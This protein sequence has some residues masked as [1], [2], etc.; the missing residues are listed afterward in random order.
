MGKNE[1]TKKKMGDFVLSVNEKPKVN[2]AD[3]YDLASLYLKLGKKE[4]IRGDV[5]FAQAIKETGYFRFNGDVS[6]NQNNYA[7]IGAIGGGVFGASFNT[8][9]EGVRAHIQHLK[10]YA[11]K[12]NLNTTKIDPRFDLVSRGIAPYW[13][14]LNGRW[15]VPGIEYGQSIIK[16]F[17]SMK[18]FS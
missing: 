1:L 16:I 5:A 3:I 6:F 4:N 2:C 11:S 14:D 17:N 18:N 15:A 9:E 12:D 13:E 8:P 10:A 7:G